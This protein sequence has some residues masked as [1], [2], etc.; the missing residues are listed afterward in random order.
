MPIW[1]FISSA[2]T[3]FKKF[4]SFCTSSWKCYFKLCPKKLVLKLS[5]AVL[6]VNITLTNRGEIGNGFSKSKGWIISSRGRRPRLEK[7]FIPRIW[8]IH[9]RSSRCSSMIFSYSVL[10]EQKF[11][12]IDF[13]PY[14]NITPKIHF[15]SLGSGKSVSVRLPSIRKRYTKNPFPYGQI[16]K[17]PSI[18][19]NFYQNWYW[20]HNFP[21]NISYSKLYGN[22]DLAQII[23]GQVMNFCQLV[24]KF[25][26]FTTKFH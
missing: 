18:W 25:N 1:K 7:W 23:L 24:W 16:A 15:H 2:F 13:Q 17:F 11:R 20:K 26:L 8:K 9:F 12:E 10:F 22:N 6:C 21:S 4:K 19:R 14:G 3:F 5:F